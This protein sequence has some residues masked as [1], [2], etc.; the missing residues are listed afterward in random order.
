MSEKG[1]SSSRPFPLLFNFSILVAR[2]T[3]QDQILAG[4]IPQLPTL[5]KCWHP[6]NKIII[7]TTT[8][9]GSCSPPS[10]PGGS[11]GKESACNAGDRGL[12]PGSGRSP[13]EGNGYPLQCLENPMDREAW[14]ATVHRLIKSQTWLSDSL[15]L[16]CKSEGCCFSRLHCVQTFFQNLSSQPSVSPS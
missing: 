7:L 4:Y 16:R 10:F 3:V 11:D 15:Q 1:G 14:W 6:S 2:I 8:S 13:G 12:I 9:T 5:T